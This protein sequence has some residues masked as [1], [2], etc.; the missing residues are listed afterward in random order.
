[1]AARRTPG[2]CSYCKGPLP[3]LYSYPE[4]EVSE[5]IPGQTI[6]RF[7]GRHFM[8]SGDRQRRK[9]L[10]EGYA[11]AG[12]FCTKDHAWRYALAIVRSVTK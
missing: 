12:F 2:R 11:G 5:A 9:Y 7:N 3:A 6:E 4:L 1:M 8:A 10:G